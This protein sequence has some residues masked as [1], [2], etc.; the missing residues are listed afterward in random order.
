MDQ[1]WQKLSFQLVGGPY[2]TFQEVSNE[3]S[4]HRGRWWNPVRSKTLPSWKISLAALLISI[5]LIQAIIG[6]LGIAAIVFYVLRVKKE[7][8][9]PVDATQLQILRESQVSA[10]V[11]ARNQI[12]VDLGLTRVEIEDAESNHRFIHAGIGSDPNPMSP[13]IFRSVTYYTAVVTP[14]GIGWHV[15][16]F[17]LLTNQFS[18][19]E[20]EL[21]LWN[22]VARVVR[23]SG[24]L[25]IEASSGSRR[26]FPLDSLKTPGDFS[27]SPESYITTMVNPFVQAAQKYLGD[28]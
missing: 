9:V 1:L 17:S 22:R 18:L 20:S 28:S 11:R 10:G 24:K 27:G 2:R 7:N 14:R 3:D 16:T 8:A 19:G 5:L 15:S 26:E 23:E 12:E 4:E 21:M 6:L 13:D 25:V